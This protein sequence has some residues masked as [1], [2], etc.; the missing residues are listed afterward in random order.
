[1]KSFLLSFLFIFSISFVNSQI[2]D[3]PD[4]NLKSYLLHSEIGDVIQIAY[5][6]DGEIFGID[7]NN[8]GEIQISEAN[9]VSRLAIDPSYY[10]FSNSISSLSGLEHFSNMTE[11]IFVNVNSGNSLDIENLS[12]VEI[13]RIFY[14]T[15]Q[16][17][18]L[19]NMTSLTELRVTNVAFNSLDFTNCNCVNLEEVSLEE[20][21]INNVNVNSLVG[22]KNFNAYFVDLQS[23]DLSSNVNL[24]QLSL[25]ATQVSQLDLSQNSNLINFALYLNGIIDVDL[26]VLPNLQ[27]VVISDTNVSTLDFSQSPNLD[28]LS[29]SDSNINFLNLKNGTFSNTS[30][31][32]FS[33]ITYLCVD[34]GNE[35]NQINLSTS[36]ISSINSYCTFNPGGDYYTVEGQ[37]KI[38]ANLNGCDVNDYPYSN[39]KFNI[40]STSNN[41]TYYADA[42]GNYSIP[43]SEGSHVISTELL[44]SE[45]FTISPNS[46]LVDFP[47]DTSPYAQDFC[48]IPN[49][50][51][52]D[53]EVVMFP[54][55]ESIPGFDAIYKL[56]YKN[57]GNTLMSGSVEL[58]YNFDSDYLQFV[59]AIP[60]NDNEVNNILSWNFS[61]L[62]PTE[63]REIFVTFNLNSPTDPIFPLDNADI[64]HYI[65]GINPINSDETPYDNIFHLVLQ[66]VNS[67]D[68]NDIRCLE[69]E[70]ILPDD[71][72]KYVHYLIRFENLGTANATNIVVK[73]TI[74]VSK[75][76]L[77]T[78]VPL[79]GSHN[80]VTRINA[81]N[82]VEFIFEDIQ[83]PFDDANNDGYL[84]YKIK[85]Q[86]SLVLGDEF[87]NQAEI[88]FDFNAPIITNNYITEITEDNLSVNDFNITD[89][90]IYPNP[91]K[92]V[93]TIKASFSIN[94]INIYDI[95]GRK[96]LQTV[97]NEINQIDMS[98]LDTGI[99]FLNLISD[100]KTET[101]KVIKH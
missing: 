11:L 8:D 42:S 74:D 85:T 92:D 18:N 15:T 73:N 99:Y 82:D 44:N 91:V 19:V 4:T 40:S 12:S 41:W 100:S 32:Y 77:N 68:P 5:N 87:T 37:N 33:N 64:L 45:Y 78:L 86:E 10:N 24:E 101:F 58:D 28:Y 9:Q 26:T 52:N 22:L 30:D 23:V 51:Y 75:F 66:V 63:S 62:A 79:D 76:D 56:K 97:Q 90:R 20:S 54:V 25:Y 69:G 80:Y 47:T 48:I 31:L 2:I 98:A 81:N 35:V 70:T 61:D 36:N 38:D 13:L 89:I 72:G 88:Y 57:N 46:V 84:V 83:L 14:P 49:G 29:I 6:L 67:Y 94:E 34:D 53:L 55:T 60:V 27:G 21:L 96:V 17:L 95:E 39:L 16:E 3:F 59:S 7:T 65:T 1:M 71:V 43:L 50:V 93:L